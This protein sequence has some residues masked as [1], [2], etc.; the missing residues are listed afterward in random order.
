MALARI[1]QPLTPAAGASHCTQLHRRLAQPVGQ[2]H[3]RQQRSLARA[4]AASGCQPNTVQA[5]EPVPVQQQQ[6]QEGRRQLLLLGVGLA[7]G[8]CVGAPPSQASVT[9]TLRPKPQLKAYTLKAGYTVTVPDN[10]SLAYVSDGL[11]DLHP[12]LCVFRTR[13]GLLAASSTDC[14][15]ASQP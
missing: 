1:M 11:A 10:W 14:H 2:Q 12:S 7:A 15:T 4:V 5:L 3:P 13:G 8:G 9:V 6:Q